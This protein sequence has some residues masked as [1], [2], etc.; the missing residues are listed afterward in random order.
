MSHRLATIYAKLHHDVPPPPPE[1]SPPTSNNDEYNDALEDDD[2]NESMSEEEEE[3]PPPCGLLHAALIGSF[4]S[5]HRESTT[6]AMHA[7]VLDNTNAAI[8]KLIA[9]IS[10]EF[11]TKVAATKKF[12]MVERRAIRELEEKMVCNASYPTWQAYRR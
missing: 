2:T 5:V 8:A 12:M 3:D 6:R 11:A 9:D 7:V 4:E 1:P 10:V